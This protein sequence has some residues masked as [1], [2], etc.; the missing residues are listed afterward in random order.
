MFVRERIRETKK[1]GKINYAY[2]VENRW[3]PVKKKYQQKIVQC[4]GR[5]DRLPRDGTIEK[6]I[7]ALDRWSLEKGFASLSSGV[8]IKDLGD[9]NILSSSLDFGEMFLTGH[10]MDALSFR[11]IFK[12][13][14]DKTNKKKISWDKF[15]TVTAAIIAY[16]LRPQVSISE[17]ATHAWY[18]D[19]LFL[20][21]KLDLSRMD[22][23]RSLDI[24]IRNKDEIEREYLNHNRTLFSEPLDLVLFDT[25]SIYYYDGEE[26]IK[27]GSILQYGFSKDGRG[28]LKQV[29]VGVLMSSEGTPIA[30]EVFPGN[31][32]DQK[33]FKEIINTV[34][35]KYNIR[36]IIF[37]ADRGMVSEENLTVIEEEEMEYILGVKMRRLPPVLRTSLLPTDPDS[38]ERVADNMYVSDFS[39]SALS[40]EDTDEL[41]K[42]LYD[43]L[44]TRVEIPKEKEKLKRR[45]L[46][47][48]MIVCF[49]PAIAKEEKEKREYFRKI[50]QNKIKYKTNKSWFVKNGYTKYIKVNKLDISLNED[51]L[52]QEELYDGVWILTTNCSKEI[53]QKT[54]GLAYKSLQFV[55]RGFRDLKSQIS[56]RPI[57]HF[58]EERIK[59]HIFVAF[60]SLVVKWYILNVINPNLQEEG[61]SFIDKILNLK[62]I[63]VD[64]SISLYVRTE[65]GKETL[66]HLDKLNVKT[67]S[68]V[69]QDSRRK[70]VKP[71]TKPGR[72]KKIPQDQ[73]KFI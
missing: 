31:K 69:L 30:H 46:K 35:T 38:M 72:P 64:H 2:L 20:K 34:K 71:P 44:D 63:E 19:S 43:D 5:T 39:L 18:R 15:Q 68:K 11:N 57:F 33:S 54:V 32:S 58:K 10:L 14:F 42:N 47:R 24:L 3:N 27:E 49:N 12:K 53:S 41:I 26:K 52:K 17:L 61:L 70:P 36:R 65:I 22:F 37:V 62:A 6:I 9:E 50:I 13:A 48:R 45:I 8:I 55:E 16:H 29:V 1:E 23:Y 56:V 4:L 67:P 25:T 7:V 28:N 40:E 73:L 51:K 60:L 59:A 66:A 21:D